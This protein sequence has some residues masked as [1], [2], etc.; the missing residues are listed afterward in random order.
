MSLIEPT[1][2]GGVDW[3]TAVRLLTERAVLTRAVCREITEAG[4]KFGEWRQCVALGLLFRWIEENLPEAL[5]Y[6]A[7]S[8]ALCQR[9]P[10]AS[11]GIDRMV[12]PLGCEGVRQEIR[13]GAEVG[14]ALRMLLTADT[15]LQARGDEAVVREKLAAYWAKHGTAVRAPAANEYPSRVYGE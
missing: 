15:P 4:D 10:R 5:R 3:G 12:V 13:D 7:A 14:D 11:D 8:G 6:Q 1:A 2:L 9:E